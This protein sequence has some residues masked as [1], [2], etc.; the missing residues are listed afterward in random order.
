MDQ[1]G[2]ARHSRVNR[3]ILSSDSGFSP[4]TRSISF[5][6]LAAL[7]L[8]PTIVTGSAPLAETNRVDTSWARSVCAMDI[9]RSR[10]CASNGVTPAGL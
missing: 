5:C 8:P 3:C 7:S 2:Q 4:V 1:P 9:G 6:T 10:V